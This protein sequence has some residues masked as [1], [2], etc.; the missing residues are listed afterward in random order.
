MSGLGDFD[1]DGRADVLWRHAATGDV[2]LWRMVGAAIGSLTY[3]ARVSDTEYRIVGA[4]DYDGDLRADVL[5]HHATGGE[6]WVWRM[7]GAA[8]LAQTWVATVSDLG[9]R[10]AVTK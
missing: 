9:Y 6:V 7:N 8:V 3:V 4:G 1:G 5:W 10:V 2:W